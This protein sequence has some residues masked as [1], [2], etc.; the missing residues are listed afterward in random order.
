M[1]NYGKNED[2]SSDVQSE[3]EDDPEPLGFNNISAISSDNQL[4]SGEGYRPFL[5][6]GLQVSQKMF[7]IKNQ[8]MRILAKMICSSLNR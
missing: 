8:N 1:W 7:Y 3:I 5:T 6:C 4:V 2:V